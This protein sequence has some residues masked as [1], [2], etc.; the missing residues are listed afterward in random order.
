MRRP[1]TL[2]M[3]G[4][5][6]SL[7]LLAA[8][9]QALH[10]ADAPVQAA[11]H[12][13]MAPEMLK[14][15][16]LVIGA[17]FAPDGAL[18]VVQQAQQNQ[19]NQQNQPSG[20]TLQIS[21]DNGQSWQ[22]ERLLDTGGDQIN[23]GGESNLK[24]AFGPNGVVLISYAQPLAKKF[25]GNIR[26][27]RST[28][29]GVH[30]AAPVTLHQDRQVISHSFANL[31]FD[32]KGLLHT[33]WLDS[34]DMVAAKEQASKAGKASPD[35]RGAALYHNVS[36]DAGASFGPDSKLADY[37]CECCRIALSATPDGQIA[38]MWR[39]V[40][41]PNIRD[42]GF[43]LLTPPQPLSPAS[44]VPIVPIV[45]IRATYD[46]WAID[47]CPHHGPGLSMAASGGYH[48]VWFG[49]RDNLAKVRYGR[50]D[51]QGKPSGSVQ[52][53]PDER[54]EHADI[55]S[56]GSQLAIVWRSYDGSNMHLKAWVSDDD[57]QHFRLQQL[58]HTEGDSDYP[59]LLK[60]TN[61][62]GKEQLF[63]IWNTTRKR[64]VEAL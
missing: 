49:V 41:A 36:Y 52:T 28:D 8:E 24:L 32:G 60:K 25:T 22:P 20:L 14:K 7:C 9:T 30:F 21:H 16:A 45:P 57:G 10:S 27:L 17:A 58:A 5:A 47:A 39:Q 48:A 46:N 34:R 63:V 13:A 31:A 15:G 19:H 64:Y 40:I 59:R 50:L 1:L 54:A 35:Y 61:Q 33:I 42:H 51:Q 26:L 11:Q 2:L 38:A 56:A 44:N 4:I 6:G 3:A 55:L 29:G 23:I 37:S 12:Q 43:A 62:D 18:W 53:L